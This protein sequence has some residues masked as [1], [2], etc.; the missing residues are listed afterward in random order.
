MATGTHK[1]DDLYLICSELHYMG[2]TCIVWLYYARSYT[3]ALSPYI[4]P[5]FSVCRPD[6]EVGA[7]GA[8]PGGGHGGQMIPPLQ[9]ENDDKL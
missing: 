3:V 2:P 9:P 4:I 1:R 7:A 8:D 5:S 6:H